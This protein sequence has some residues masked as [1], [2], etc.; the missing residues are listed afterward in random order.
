MYIFRKQGS[1]LRSGVVI[2]LLSSLLLMAGCG[3]L[4]L[5]RGTVTVFLGSLMMMCGNL[6]G[7]AIFGAAIR[8]CT[9]ANKAGM[10]QGLRIFGCVLVPGVVGPAIGA[11]VLKNAQQV[12]NSDGTTSFVPNEN[13]FLT[14]VLMTALVWAVL[15]PLFQALKKGESHAH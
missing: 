14:A 10:F 11:A 1:I 15:I 9:P 3:V 6:G 5:F 4:Y 12:I 8:D 13:L 7:G 2:L